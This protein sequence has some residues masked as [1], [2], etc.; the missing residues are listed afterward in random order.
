[1]NSLNNNN[2]EIIT[3]CLFIKNFITLDSFMKEFTEKYEYYEEVLPFDLCSDLFLLDSLNKNDRISLL[4]RLKKYLLLHYMDFYCKINDSFVEKTIDERN[5]YNLPSEI[6]KELITK[7]QQT[8][9]IEI[10]CA[11]IETEYELICTLHC[12]LHFP[13]YWGMNW[14]ATFDYMSDFTP[15]KKLLIKNIDILKA[16]KI[17]GIDL[18]LYAISLIHDKQCIIKFI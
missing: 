16:R 5:P 4:N 14:D 13:S 17:K 1:M 12:K 11:E 6:F 9:L 7:N 15:P 10:D 3:L 18:F 2:N 8:E